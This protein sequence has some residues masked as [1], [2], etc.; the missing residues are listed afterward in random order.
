MMKNKYIILV[1]EWEM[2]ELSDKQPEILLSW[3]KR[4]LRQCLKHTNA[5]IYPWNIY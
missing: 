4:E 3:N 2:G 5:T 1:Y